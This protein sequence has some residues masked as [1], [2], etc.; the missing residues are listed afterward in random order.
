[1][2]ADCFLLGVV[3]GG[4]AVIVTLGALFFYIEKRLP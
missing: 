4:V 2:I 1:M 3:V